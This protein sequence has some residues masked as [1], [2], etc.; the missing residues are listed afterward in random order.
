MFVIVWRM[1]KEYVA[2]MKTTREERVSIDKIFKIL[3]I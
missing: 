1:H 3:S 2:A